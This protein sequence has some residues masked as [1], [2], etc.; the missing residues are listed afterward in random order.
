MKGHVEEMSAMDTIVV[1]A[2][3]RATE[4]VRALM[5]ELEQELSAQYLPEQRQALQLDAIFQPHIRFF[6]ARAEGVAVGCGGVALFQDFAEVKRMYVRTAARGRGVAQALMA[7]IETEAR[8]AGHTLLRLETGKR[9]FAAMRFYQ[10]SGFTTCEAF[11]D[12]AS[13][14][15]N[16][17][18][19]SVFFEKRL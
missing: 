12:Y 9:Q 5:F 18:A 7:R 13:M 4:E 10:L 3:P 8:Q 19:T 16:T 11:G 14:A 6:L 17:I 2:A 1:E 15:A